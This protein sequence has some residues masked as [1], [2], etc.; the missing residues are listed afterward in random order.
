MQKK[1]FKMQ[2]NLIGTQTEQQQ[3]TAGKCEQEPEDSNH[4]H[5]CAAFQ[6]SDPKYF[7]VFSLIS[8]FAAAAV[9]A[10]IK[11]YSSLSCCVIN[12]VKI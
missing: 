12:V 11:N 3:Q 1:T 8:L 9:A 4:Q 5:A 2:S 10:A 6:K 7:H